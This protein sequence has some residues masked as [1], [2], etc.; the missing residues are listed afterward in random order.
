MLSALDIAVLPGSTDIICPIKV[1]EYMA[2]GLPA[3]VP[4]YPCNREVIAD[5]VTGMLFEPKNERALADKILVLAKDKNMRQ[6]MGDMARQEVLKRF[7]WE[8]TW[9]RALNEVFNRLKRNAPK[10]TKHFEAP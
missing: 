7:T 9:G 1:Q 10:E 4:D 2:S 3:I 5:G 8:E 6:H